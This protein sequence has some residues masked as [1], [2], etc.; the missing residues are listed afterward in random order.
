MN[1]TVAPLTL[2]DGPKQGTLGDVP[3]TMSFFFGVKLAADAV[4]NFL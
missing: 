1:T 4:H 2:Q 3:T